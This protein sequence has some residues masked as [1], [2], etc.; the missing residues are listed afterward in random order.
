MSNFNLYYRLIN[1][2]TDNLRP[3]SI[4]LFYSKIFLTILVFSMF[5]KK[6][7]ANKNTLMGTHTASI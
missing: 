5:R 4:N 3:K 2:V 6:W 1:Y 7:L